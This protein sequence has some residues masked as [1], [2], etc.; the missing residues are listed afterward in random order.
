MTLSEIVARLNLKH[1]IINGTIYCVIE[2]NAYVRYPHIR[3]ASDDEILEIKERN[4]QIKIHS[5]LKSYSV[6]L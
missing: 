5:L 3:P 2:D 4:R 1:R 6:K